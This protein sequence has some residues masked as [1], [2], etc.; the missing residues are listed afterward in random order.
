MGIKSNIERISCQVIIFAQ[1]ESEGIL[2]TF[3][4][5]LSYGRCTF[6]YQG[7]WEGSNEHV[8][9]VYTSATYT[10]EPKT[11]HEIRDHDRCRERSA[12][13]GI[14]SFYYMKKGKAQSESAEFQPNCKEQE[15]EKASNHL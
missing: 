15:N 5:K 11:M 13:K 9:F 12:K 8:T 14:A 7:V 1:V 10:Q 3:F 6:Q 2:E 4:P